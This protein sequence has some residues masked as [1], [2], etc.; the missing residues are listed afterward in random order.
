MKDGPGLVLGIDLGTT[1]FKAAL[2]SRDGRLRGLGRAEVTKVTGE[3]GIC[4]LPP[5]H[6][7]QF[8][9]NCV[10][11][12]L[13]QAGCG[14]EAIAALAYS[15]QANSFLVLDPE[16]APLT[17]LILW[18]DQR[19]A[20]MMAE[21]CRLTEEPDFIEV[22]GLGLETTEFCIAKLLW[23]RKRSPDLWARI[24]RVQTISDF[25]ISELTGRFVGDEG[26]ASLLG[27][28]DLQTHAWWERAFHTLD[29]APSWFS[30]PLPP[31]TVAG[32]T[33]PVGAA[34]IGL[35]PGTVVV[36]GS[37]DHH[38]A[39]IGAGIRLLEEAGI[40]LGTV[41]ACLCYRDSYLPIRNCCMGRGVHN[42]P[43]YQI[44][45]EG[46]GTGALDWYRQSS[47]PGLSFEALNRLASAVPPGCDG[48]MALPSAQNYPMGEGFRNAL[49]RHG[50]GHFVRAMM[51][52]TA[53]SLRELLGRLRPD[54]SLRRLIATGGGAKSDLWLQIISDL[55]GFEVCVPACDEPACLGAAMMAAV[56][57]GWFRDLDNAAL[58]WTGVV[59][60]I[61]P[62]PGK[63]RYYQEWYE[64]YRAVPLR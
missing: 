34:R 47:A 13:S 43:Y 8:V 49:G 14:G 18:P 20:G 62:D 57:A 25:F 21:L 17:A 33:T 7:W 28:W 48:L 1:Y 2:Y 29:L 31:S 52:S 27:L 15:S 44:A 46:N 30:K 36:V 40:S 54:A 35:Q 9:R 10:H 22:T 6:F 59:R 5:E 39:A 3:E 37:L 4:E 12:A 38:V 61:T 42:H 32:A 53:A 60:R 23:L 63:H 50:H 24:A 16:G 64:Q 41:V 19:A 11:A 55:T 45:F 58:E 51:E 26:T 56:A